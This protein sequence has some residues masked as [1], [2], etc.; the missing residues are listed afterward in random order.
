M[1]KLFFLIF[2][3][4][5]F[6][7]F[8]GAQAI[9]NIVSPTLV[10][11]LPATCNPNSAPSA[12][13]L[14]IIYRKND[15][16]YYCGE[17]NKYT[18][19]GGGAS[20]GGLTSNGNES[21]RTGE[22]LSQAVTRIG[23]VNKK[24]LE[25]TG[26]TPLTANLT[27]PANIA[28]K[29]YGGS[30]LTSTVAVNVA[31]KNGLGLEAN[32]NQFIFRGLTDVD[33]TGSYPRVTYP[34]WFGATGNGIAD[35]AA[36]MQKT[37]DSFQYKP[38]GINVIAGGGVELACGKLY[39]SSAT[40]IMRN[41]LRFYA[42]GGTELRGCATI[43]FTNPNAVGLRTHQT[44]TETGVST[45]NDSTGNIIHGI[46]FE[47]A[48]TP[49]ISDYIPTHTVNIGT[50]SGGNIILTRQTGDA[51]DARQGI[52]EGTTVNIGSS[53][54][55]LSGVGSTQPSAD[56]LVLHP[57]RF[58]AR[59]VGNDIIG[60][61]DFHRNDPAWL[62]QTVN[63]DNRIYTI[64]E[65]LTL[66]GEAKYFRLNRVIDSTARFVGSVSIANNS[67]VLT[68]NNENITSV[69]TDR[70]VYV[71]G[72]SKGFIQSFTSATTAILSQT[73]TAGAITAQAAEFKGSIDYEGQI[74][75]YPATANKP[76]RINRFHGLELR[77]KSTVSN[78]SITGFA[79]DGININ[80]NLDPTKG[81]GT[82]PNPNN[83]IIRDNLVKRNYGNGLFF[84]GVNSNKC[85]VTSN[86]FTDNQGFGVYDRSFL[87]INYYSNHASFNRSGAILS[88]GI[89][90]VHYGDYTEGGQASSIFGE[91]AFYVG[92]TH[93]AG[94]SVIE[95]ANVGISH[96]D[97][98][99][100]ISSSLKISRQPDEAG[101]ATSQQPFISLHLGKGTTQEAG[102]GLS[103]A[104]L[105]FGAGDDT[106]SL[107]GGIPSSP[108]P[109][110]Q[111]T[112]GKGGL[113]SGWLSFNYNDPQ[114]LS[115]TSAMMAFSGSRS[116]VGAG[117]VW[118]PKGFFLGRADALRPICNAS[119]RGFTFLVHAASGVQD[120]LQLCV[121]N[122]DS[123]FSWQGI[124]FTT[125][126]TTAEE[127]PPA[128]PPVTTATNYALPVNGGTASATTEFNAS[129]PASGF[130]N[131]ERRST[132]YGAGGGWSSITAPSV[133]APQTAT[134]TFPQT[135][136]IN[137]INLFSLPSTIGDTAQPTLT[138]TTTNANT[139]F[140][141]EILNGTTWT[142]LTTVTGNNKTWYQTLPANISADGIRAV[143]TESATT[144]A[145][146]TEFEAFY[147]N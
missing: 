98:N 142:I 65:L 111:Y 23:T 116:A 93:G 67:N 21:L 108:Y 60:M 145:V 50:D 45:G 16:L 133:T 109:A 40:L 88:L 47:G 33:F 125:A 80:S 146:V 128:P 83:C 143:I 37:F 58:V 56:V 13:N 141:I 136:T 81:S 43:R 113:G 27:I 57:L 119:K 124:P 74:T 8:V 2:S 68:I 139:N 36:A 103:T 61:L 138:D 55:Y 127:T 34:E 4:L 7:S 6:T 64:T 35:D 144:Q 78:V 26:E 66:E 72:V 38:D 10:T 14:L 97:R 94:F 132:D 135:R 147:R 77:S 91:G 5:L 42:N 99:E 12:A 112:Y 3:I 41:A 53:V 85:E 20:T 18:R 15:G 63:I 140:T 122:A 134:I 62:N 131:G 29:F 1:R 105:G 106:A 104:L 100:L 123:T 69:E 130:I 121:R 102:N 137:E 39:Q 17:L 107:N 75:S 71:N 90:A 110:W 51:F 49:T 19:G 129:Y 114:R 89:R 126:I 76:I 115:P 84:R 120:Q 32:P 44:S 87:G 95:G 46:N 25:L 54:W 70:Y 52:V 28:L 31:I 86:D 79:G 96:S 92:G 82:E 30:Y 59:A 22:T 117:S 73:N 9:K 48:T 101:A 24:T 11:T 118:F